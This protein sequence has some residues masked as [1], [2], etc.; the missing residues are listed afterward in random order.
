MPSMN[1]AP[2]VMIL[3]LGMMA[4]GDGLHACS[5]FCV[6]LAGGKYFGRNYDFEIG[7][8]MVMVNPSGLRKQGFEARGPR[9][10]ARFGSVTFNQFGRDQP[11]GGMNERSL[12]VELMWLDGTRYP[13]P[14]ARLPLGVLEWIQYQ[15]DTAA[16]VQDVL[17]SHAAVRIRGG[18]PL[19]Y[20]VSDGA[21]RAATVEFIDGRLV[22]HSDAALPVRVL[23][24]TPYRE[25]LAYLSRGHGQM[26]AG[27]GSNERFARAAL[28]IAALKAHGT[29]DPIGALFTVLDD[30]A[31]ANT[32]W[33]IVYDQT[34]RVIHF[35]TDTHRARR[36]V[37]FDDLEF[38]CAAGARLLDIDTKVAGD[39]AKKFKPYTAAANLAFI[40]R[41]YAGSSVTRGTP[42]TEV[43]AIAAQPDL[44][45]CR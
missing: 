5:T 25:A 12:V 42:A 27:P 15:L 28:Q 38:G 39:V 10:T 34:K 32:R 37:A 33:S 30:V 18:A 9:W 6:H 44:A 16:T 20:L 19:H 43:A 3:A 4:L 23:T 14:D 1:R 7:D 24:N 22:A 31:Q 45:A 29:A 2:C 17:D 41:T 35:R 26:P 11:M 8:G 36:H 21:G 40:T 13:A